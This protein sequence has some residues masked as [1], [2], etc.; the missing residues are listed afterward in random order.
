MEIDTNSYQE[1]SNTSNTTNN[2]AISL[3]NL[4]ET[5]TDGKADDSVGGCSLF[6]KDESVE[7][8]EK[9]YILTEETEQAAAR[10]HFEKYA[11]ASPGTILSQ[12]GQWQTS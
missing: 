2:Q 8:V 10:I 6:D 11:K 7:L 5:E 4:T 1:R 12:A 9:P 3:I